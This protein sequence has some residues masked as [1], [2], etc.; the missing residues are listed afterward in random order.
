M[1]IKEESES[2]DADSSG[3]VDPGESRAAVRSR[4]LRPRG[5]EAQRMTAAPDADASGGVHFAQFLANGV[6][7][8]RQSR[9]CCS[10]D[11]LGYS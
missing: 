2:F 10:T 5:G 3:E 7:N 1:H 4:G 11:G 9:Y 6:R 8:R